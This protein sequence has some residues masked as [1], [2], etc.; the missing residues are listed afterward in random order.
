MINKLN[1][2]KIKENFDF[3]DLF[4]SQ[5]I[6]NKLGIEVTLDKEASSKSAKQYYI[7]GA[8]RIV[9][10]ERSKLGYP[11]Y[12]NQSNE[13]DK[14]DVIQFVANRL[15]INDSSANYEAAKLI[16]ESTNKLSGLSPIIER[17]GRAGMVKRFVLE[18]F[19][20]K[21]LKQYEKDL[22]T[23]LTTQ[24]GINPNLFQHPNFVGLAFIYFPFLNNKAVQNV[25]FAKKDIAGNIIGAEIKFPKSGATQNTNIVEGN[26][27]A[28]WYSNRPTVVEKVILCESALDC[29]SHFQVNMDTNVLYVSSNGNLYQDRITSFYELLKALEIGNEVPIM[30]A[31]DNDFA[32]VQ[33]D[34]RMANSE[35]GSNRSFD[36][37]Q[38]KGKVTLTYS[39]FNA[40]QDVMDEIRDYFYVI[41]IKINNL[42]MAEKPFL[43]HFVEISNL[44][45]SVR[46][47]F[48]KVTFEKHAR[49]ISISLFE[50]ISILKKTRLFIN[51]PNQSKSGMIKDWNDY[52]LKFAEE[53]AR[54]AKLANKGRNINNL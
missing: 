20:K 44:T 43:N 13:S 34:L 18:D 21:G 14:G 11:F 41:K 38:E 3:N 8:E 7:N 27:K 29:L 51:K 22:I 50:T 52:S 48:P 19:K 53:Q 1:Y 26:P 42:E 12:T 37:I 2:D 46:L 23:F 31:G 28:L 32:G 49:K 6:L 5:T 40:N 4:Q 24:R 16:M 36:L 45:S 15:G 35:I 33:Y 9:V 54:N 30:L 25:F 10:Y 47:D 39:D 17:K